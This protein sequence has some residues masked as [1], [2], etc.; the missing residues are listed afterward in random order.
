MNTLSQEQ[1]SEIQKDIESAG[2]KIAEV[3]KEHS[4]AIAGKVVKIEIAQGV[5]G[6]TCQVGYISTKFQEEKKEEAPKVELKS[7]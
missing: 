5:Y 1:L 3:L 7:E 6:D 2:T 4:L